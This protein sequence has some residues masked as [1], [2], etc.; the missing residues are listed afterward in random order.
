MLTIKIWLEIYKKIDKSTTLVR[1]LNKNDNWL[2]FSVFPNLLIASIQPV[3]DLIQGLTLNDEE[4][5]KRLATEYWAERSTVCVDFVVTKLFADYSLSGLLLQTF[6][7]NIIE[8][9][10]HYIIKTYNQL[11]D[12]DVRYSLFDKTKNLLNFLHF[13]IIPWI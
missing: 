4:Y 10:H 8:T 9:F 2:F 11:V 5:S 6:H 3:D 1:P 7:K 13:T 12:A